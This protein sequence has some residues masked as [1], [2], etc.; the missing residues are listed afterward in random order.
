VETRDEVV[1]SGLGLVTPRTLGRRSVIARLRRP[2]LQREVQ[3]SL[4]ALEVLLTPR[5]ADEPG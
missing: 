2:M 4:D 5:P 3:R 1:T